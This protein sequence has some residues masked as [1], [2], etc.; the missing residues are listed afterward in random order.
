M[1]LTPNT[2][3]G[4]VAHGAAKPR[5]QGPADREPDQDRP[6]DRGLAVAGEWP[7]DEGDG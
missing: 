3:A 1:P 4:T 6:G 7:G 5:Q 2:V